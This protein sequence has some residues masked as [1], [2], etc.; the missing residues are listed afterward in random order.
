MSGRYITTRDE[1]RELFGRGSD[2]GEHCPLPMRM[3]EPPPP[4]ELDDQGDVELEL[5]AFGEFAGKLGRG[6]P[7]EMPMEVYEQLGPP[8]VV[9]EVL[10]TPGA[11]GSARAFLNKRTGK[12]QLAPG[13][14][15]S[16]ERK[17][18][19]W[20]TA[21]RERALEVV[22]ERES[23]VFVG[24]AL[25]VEITFYLARPAGHWG[26]GRNAGKLA[27]SAPPVPIGK[28]D[29]D[30]LERATVDALT[31]IVFDDDA[32]IVDGAI[33]KRYA[34]PGR[35]GARITIEPWSPAPSDCQ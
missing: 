8:R 3:A 10:G 24:Q 21:V 1:A 14:A 27:P 23:P 6:A 2:L 32:R 20:E 31:G 11:K 22:G 26:K 5:V 15:K 19:A 9:L 18:K 16:T 7:R 25:T 4:A 12:A 28:P 33:R 30:K 29:R 13:G 17:V 35:E 34:Q